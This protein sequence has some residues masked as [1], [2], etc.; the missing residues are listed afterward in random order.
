M[1]KQAS[2]HCHLDRNVLF[3]VHT[4]FFAFVIWC[5][6]SNC[7]S[8][9]RNQCGRVLFRQP[10]VKAIIFNVISQWRNKVSRMIYWL[11]GW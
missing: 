8:W 11:K 3:M 4:A 10:F 2:K 7:S 1:F 5:K 9:L 6:F